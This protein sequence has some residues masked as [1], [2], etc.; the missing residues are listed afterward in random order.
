MD[1]PKTLSFNCDRK[2]G[3]EME[4]CDFKH[5]DFKTY[6]LDK[7]ELP[8][9]MAEI[10]CLLGEKLKT[11]VQTN[12]WHYT[13]NN[14]SWVLKP[15]SSCGIE[16][17]APVYRGWNGLEKVCIATRELANDK[18]ITVDDR[19]GLHVHVDVSDCSSTQINNILAYWI[20]CESVFLDSV[21]PNR[22]KNRYC[23]QIG[24][25]PLFDVESEIS[26]LLV[27]Q[28]GQVKYYTINSYH[29]Q[30][31][32]RNTLEWR[33]M[34]GPGCLDPYLVKNWVR[35]VV[36]FVECAKRRP[37]PKK[38]IAGD[39]WTS[40][41]WLD[42]MDVME[43]LGFFGPISKGL[44]EV[45]DWFVARIHANLFQHKMMGV[46]SP[47]CRAV[48]KKQLDEIVGR[49]GI[50]DKICNILHPID[51]EKALFDPERRV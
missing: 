51:M 36:Y 29:M 1:T 45:R 13:H 8:E 49:L 17:C 34:E 37:T 40:L 48:A 25:S 18:R 3:V 31:G 5:R 20:K 21:P 27:Q 41:C 2:F 43:F 16:I 11:Q 19:C 47:E 28:L 50:S 4:V 12:K 35:L 15:D 33:I 39:P 10:A 23:Q 22:K 30:R 26:G 42:P 38:Y 24:I 14:E 6:P 44:E 46:W 32:D 9:G 7:G